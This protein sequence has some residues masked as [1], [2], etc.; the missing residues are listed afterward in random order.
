MTG[1]I[2]A[3]VVG[4]LIGASVM[5]LVALVLIGTADEEE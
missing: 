3:A 4:M 2:I 1:Y 5:V